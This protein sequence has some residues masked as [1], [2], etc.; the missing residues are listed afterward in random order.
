MPHKRRTDTH[1]AKNRFVARGKRGIA[2]A[3]LTTLFLFDTLTLRFFYRWL[4][5]IPVVIGFTTAVIAVGKAKKPARWPA[6]LMLLICTLSIAAHTYRASYTPPIFTAV[7]VRNTETQQVIYLGMSKWAVESELGSPVG[8]AQVLRL[9]NFGLPMRHK[10]QYSYTGGIEVAYWR[11]TVQSCIADTGR[12]EVVDQRQ[13]ATTQSGYYESSG[14]VTHGYLGYGP[15]G[16]WVRFGEH[17]ATLDYS[18]SS[19]GTPGFTWH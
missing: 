9:P 8:V 1:Q 15:D 5:L 2:L 3:G 13:E 16:V 14:R 11:E 18:W 4:I 17:T 6:V 10:S 7:G 19:P 12:W